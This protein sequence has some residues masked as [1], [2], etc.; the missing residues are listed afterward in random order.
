MVIGFLFLPW[1]AVLLFELPRSPDNMAR[2]TV[3]TTVFGFL[4]GWILGCWIGFR[5]FRSR[6][7]RSESERARANIKPAA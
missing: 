1:L 2:V 3:A 5:D 6:T 7:R 4:S